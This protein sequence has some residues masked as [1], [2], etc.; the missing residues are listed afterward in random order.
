MEDGGTSEVCSSLL[1]VDVM[2]SCRVSVFVDRLVVDDESAAGAW[3]A[4]DRREMQGGL[5]FRAA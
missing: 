3:N 5:P 2:V 4:D 1:V